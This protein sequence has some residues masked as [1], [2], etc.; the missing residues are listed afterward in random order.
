MTNTFYEVKFLIK[1]KTKSVDQR[2]LAAVWFQKVAWPLILFGSNC[3]IVGCCIMFHWMF[4]CEILTSGLCDNP[5]KALEALDWI[6]TILLH[7]PVKSNSTQVCFRDIILVCISCWY[8][9]NLLKNA[10]FTS[11]CVW[12]CNWIQKQHTCPH[13][14]TKSRESENRISLLSAEQP[15]HIPCSLQRLLKG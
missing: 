12:V 8:V 11:N 6:L 3:L 15:D 7:V 1:Q 9:H 13:I 4:A 14:H 5:D 10:N 2:H